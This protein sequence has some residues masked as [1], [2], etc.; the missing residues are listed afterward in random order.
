MLQI[1]IL[2]IMGATLYSRI[3]HPTLKTAEGGTKQRMNP[4]L[5]WVFMALGGLL[6]V[7]LTFN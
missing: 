5:Y 4:V 1:G 3:K 7:G 2:F 6:A